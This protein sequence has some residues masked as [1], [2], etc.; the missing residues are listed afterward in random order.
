MYFFYV[1]VAQD[2]IVS[3]IRSQIFSTRTILRSHEV[4]HISSDRY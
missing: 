1:R 4:L 3:G 2:F